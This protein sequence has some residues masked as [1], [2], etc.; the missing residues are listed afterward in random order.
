MICSDL[1]SPGH[2]NFLMRNTYTVFMSYGVYGISI[3]LQF[4]LD[5]L[6]VEHS[7]LTSIQCLV[8]MTPFMMYK[9]GTVPGA[10]E[11]ESGRA[12]PISS[13]QWGEGHKS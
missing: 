5:N 6:Y 9:L 4:L 8:H 13:Q 10:R 2:T 12:L 3:S 11:R 7:F 1:A